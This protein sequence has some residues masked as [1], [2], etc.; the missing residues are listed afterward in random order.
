[1]TFPIIVNEEEKRRPIVVPGIYILYKRW[2]MF[3]LLFH[4]CFLAGWMNS[5]RNVIKNFDNVMY[6]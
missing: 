1:M 5:F 4:F 3:F 6:N 2:C